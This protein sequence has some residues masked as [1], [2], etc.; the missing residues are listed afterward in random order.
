MENE[1]KKIGS[2]LGGLSL[3]PNRG[4]R[5]NCFRSLRYVSLVLCVLHRERWRARMCHANVNGMDQVTV[6]AYSALRDLSE[7]AADCCMT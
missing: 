4:E 7:W 3:F 1:K 2:L 5:A 6:M